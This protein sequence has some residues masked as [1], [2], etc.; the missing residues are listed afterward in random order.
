MAKSEL[1]LNLETG[2]PYVVALVAIPN[3]VQSDWGLVHL[4]GKLHF[5]AESTYSRVQPRTPA[6]SKK[7][8]HP[9]SGSGCR[10]LRKNALAR[11]WQ[12]QDSIASWLRFGLDTEAGPTIFSTRRQR[13]L[14]PFGT[15]AS[16]NR[17]HAH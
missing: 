13:V 16:W 6:S 5:Q 15:R 1:T 9:E 11:Q 10:G 8:A 17:P 12:V 4:I 7:T 3:P 2:V 14:A